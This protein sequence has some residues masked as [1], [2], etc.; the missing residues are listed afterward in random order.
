VGDNS[1]Q[2]SYDKTHIAIIPLTVLILSKSFIDYSTSG[3]ENSIEFLLLAIFCIQLFGTIVWCKTRL[4]KL[5]LTAALLILTRMD[6]VLLVL[7][8]LIYAMSTT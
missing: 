3:L 8:V 7:P 4:F 5:A 1:H 6:L 2:N